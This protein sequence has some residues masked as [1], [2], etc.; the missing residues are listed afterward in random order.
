MF[1]RYRAI[2]STKVVVFIAETLHC[3][4]CNIVIVILSGCDFQLTMN[5][6]FGFLLTGFRDNL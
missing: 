3:N 4:S 1:N 5:T 6:T 2:I